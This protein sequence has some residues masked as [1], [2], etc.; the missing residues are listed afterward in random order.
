M[1]NLSRC[2]TSGDASS[3]DS[4]DVQRVVDSSLTAEEMA[5]LWLQQDLYAE[6]KVA[7][8]QALTGFPSITPDILVSS[9][10][11]Q[12]T[13]QKTQILRQHTQ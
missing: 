4:R 11:T 3:W 8:R 9:F 5:V 1:Q 13:M 2:Y 6:L 7:L 12:H 10:H